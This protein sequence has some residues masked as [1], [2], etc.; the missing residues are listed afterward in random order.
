MSKTK[1]TTAHAPTEMT[2]TGRWAKKYSHSTRHGYVHRNTWYNGY[3]CPVCGERRNRLANL[4][5]GG[6][7]K[8]PMCS[9]VSLRPRNS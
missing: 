5:K 4:D 9:G 8:P 3:A 7:L 6:R 2:F 1:L